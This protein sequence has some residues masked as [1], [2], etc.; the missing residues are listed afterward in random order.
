MVRRG[1]HIP[2]VMYVGEGNMLKNCCVVKDIEHQEKKEKI[3]EL[4]RMKEFAHL[5]LRLG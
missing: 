1:L 2:M 3:T 5:F 4:Q